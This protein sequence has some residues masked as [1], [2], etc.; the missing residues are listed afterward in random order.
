MGAVRKLLAS[1]NLPDR[2]KH[3]SRIFCDLC[4]NIHIHYREYRLVFSLDEY[5]EF[6]DIIE[7]STRDVRNYLSQN[8]DYGEREYATTVIIAGGPERQRKFIHNSPQ[9]NRSTYDNNVCRIELNEETVIDEVHIHYRDFRIAMNRSCFREFVK[10]VQESVRELDT[11]EASNTYLRRPHTDRRISPDWSQ[12]AHIQESDTPTLGVQ[13]LE[14]DQLKSVHLRELPNGAP[15]WCPDPETIGLLKAA[16]QAGE[17][18]A[19]ILVTKQDTDGKYFVIDGHHRLQAF[20][21][22]GLNR[23]PAIITRFDWKGSEPLR[24]VE[25]TLKKLD[26]ETRYCYGLSDFFKDYIAYKA[27]CHYRNHF[28]R[29]LSRSSRFRSWRRATMRNVKDFVKGLVGRNSES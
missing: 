19:P 6:A 12:S 24:L 17:R 8:S 16:I 13:E 28:Q 23:I 14:M 20:K 9:P 27:N 11:F 5:L 25:R 15:G 7:K 29:L 2:E 22:L 1:T 3:N 10:T 4:E 18:V 21:V 26:A